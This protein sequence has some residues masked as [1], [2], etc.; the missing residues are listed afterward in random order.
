MQ[1]LANNLFNSINLLSNYACSFEYIYIYINPLIK[2]VFKV[3][4]N[5]LFP[6]ACIIRAA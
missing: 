3:S 5:K 2:N 1:S 4:K 6:N